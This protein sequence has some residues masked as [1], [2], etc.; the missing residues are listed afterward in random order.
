[1]TKRKIEYWV[2]P[3]D[4]DA[5]FVADMEERAR[6]L[7]RS[8]RSAAPGAV[9][10][11]TTGAIAEGD[12]GADRRDEGAS[13][14]VSITNTNATARRASS[15]SRNRC[16]AFARRPPANVGPRSTGRSKWPNCWTRVTPT[17]AK[18][19]LVCDN[20]NTHTKGAFYD[21]VPARASA[22]VYQADQLLL[23]AQARQLAEHR[24][25]RVELPDEPMPERPPHR[26]TAAAAIGDR[27]LGRQDQRQTTRRRL[28]I[29]NRRRPNKTEAA[30]PEDLEWMR[31]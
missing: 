2:I 14:S 25:M 3:P 16:R 15:C 24:R 18:V 31:H 4:Q 13:R 6:D 12:E 5:E 26:R 30:V 28:A 8:V 9:H 7:C 11:R 19:T 20:L 27:D 17:C 10:G 29:Q 23:H 22:G 21:G 1:M